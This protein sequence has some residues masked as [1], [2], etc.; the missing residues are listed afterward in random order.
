MAE[1]NS[2]SDLMTRLQSG[3]DAAAGEVFHRFARRLIGLARSQLDTKLR[4]KVDPEDVVQSVYKSFFRRHEAEPF[5]LGNWDS[6]WS[7]LTVITVRKCAKRAEYH[8]AER[9]HPR[10][11]VRLGPADESGSWMQLI[12]RE[13]TPPDAALLT[14]TVEQVL[15]GFDP[16]DR[17]V[18]EMSLQGYTAQEISAGLNRAERTV[19]RLRERVKKRLQALL[20]SDTIL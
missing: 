9:R 14:E 6:L 13:P 10:K 2:F 1:A 8:H 7:L 5:D 16:E 17:A 4:H 3:D 19:R 12:D 18:I 15:R 11:E 20:A